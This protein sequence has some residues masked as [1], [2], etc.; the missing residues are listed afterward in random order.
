MADLLLVGKN[1]ESKQG[2]E[3]F[4]HCMDWWYEIV[5]V[6]QNALQGRFAFDEHFRRD[7]MLAPMTPTMSR[8]DCKE[9]S[10]LVSEIVNDG[11]A[12]EQLERLYREDPL[13]IQAQEEFPGGLDKEH[14]LEQMQEFALFLDQCGGCQA[15]WHG[16]EES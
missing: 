12:G 16:Q 14:R 7:L 6:L 11:S 5:M 9:L 1:P 15:K 10:R 3:Y 2:E 8:E 4:L 13:L